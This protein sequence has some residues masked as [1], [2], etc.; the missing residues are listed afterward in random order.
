VA[1]AAGAE[2]NTDPNPVLLVGKDVNVVI[3]GPNRSKL[4]LSHPLQRVDLGGH[5]PTGMVFVENLGL[6]LLF[7]IP[8]H[9]E[10]D[11]SK[12][13]VH[14]S[15]DIFPRLGTRHIGQNGLVSA[16]DIVTNTARGD[17]VPV[18]HDPSDRDGIALMVVSHQGHTI[19][20]QGT[21]FDLRKGPSSTGEP[22]IGMPS[23]TFIEIAP[24]LVY[25]ALRGPDGPECRTNSLQYSLSRSSFQP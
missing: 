24:L 10:G 1:Q 18:R 9:S 14:D 15:G 12:H 5:A 13:I 16:R 3:A 2:V 11:G 22:Q 7:V 4:V 25:T 23:T 6:H 17:C 20:G 21:G 19:R 8:A